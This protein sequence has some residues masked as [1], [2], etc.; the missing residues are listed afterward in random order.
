[1]SSVHDEDSERSPDDLG[2]PTFNAKPVV[3][4]P[5]ADSIGVNA[6]P[7]AS[8]LASICNS[9]HTISNVSAAPSDTSVIRL[10]R[11]EALARTVHLRCLPPFLKQKALADVFEDCGEYLRVRI[12]GNATTHQKWVYG[13]VEFATKDAAMKMMTYCGMELPNGPDKPPLRFKCSPSKQPILDCMAYDADV[14]KGTP[15]GFGRG[16]LAERTLNDVLLLVG[17]G[18]SNTN[19]TTAG[20]ASSSGKGCCGGGVG[21]RRMR[22]ANNAL[23]A[24]TVQSI[25]KVAANG[26]GCGCSGVN[27]CGCC[28]CWKGLPES[29][30]STTFGGGEI[31]SGGS[32]KGTTKAV[33]ATVPACG[34]AGCANGDGVS[35]RETYQGD[36][37]ATS[38][39]KLPQL[40][41]TFSTFKDL[42][43]P[44]M[45]PGGGAPRD[46]MQQ[47]ATAFQGLR[48]ST[49]THEHQLDGPSIV[50]RAEAMV[51]A[52]LHRAFHVSSDTC[53]QDILSELTQVLAFLD[54][55]AAVTGGA[56]QTA[57][58]DSAATL[59]QRVT[60]L[61]MLAN[62]VGALLCLLRRRVGDA[63]PH[64]EAVLVIFAQIPPSTLL[65]RTRQCGKVGAVQE[66]HHAEKS[67]H[68]QVLGVSHG[69]RGPGAVEGATAEL[70]A[71]AVYS[72][73]KRRS[74]PSPQLSVFVD[75]DVT[76]PLLE[77]LDEDNAYDGIHHIG[78]HDDPLE[79]NDIESRD[80][81]TALLKHRKRSTSSCIYTRD[82]FPDSADPTALCLRDELFSRYVLHA[83]VSVGL[84]MEEVHPGIARSVYTLANGRAMEV[85]G[86][87]SKVLADQ[88]ATAPTSNPHLC[89]ALFADA[90]TTDSEPDITFFP[91]QFF[92]G[93]SVVLQRLR[94]IRGTEEFWR[95]LPPNHIVT[96]FNT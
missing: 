1:M 86:E 95:Q 27:C 29:T 96:L 66:Q 32:A 40:T 50:Q 8:L 45:L 15:C 89:A 22:A 25:R 88:L 80:D 59:P 81:G 46:I 5:V 41:A 7:A 58:G 19:P 83:L 47:L 78:N 74:L 94:D 84:A 39:G 75:G 24:L 73:I 93:V 42:Q 67:K 90:Y 54:S 64:V 51:L 79:E 34:R 12:C 38:A 92:E 20:G 69:G 3:A 30:G 18:G 44:L 60:Q 14:V 65:L 52:A 2:S 23:T 57:S 16:Y 17:G 4:A 49:A 10:S 71:P 68:A 72:L 33:V 85:F 48:D 77:M 13:F 55:N 6:P 11:T 63:L 87:S 26:C 31:P 9:T 82:A 37:C 91:H 56:A 62:L 35:E 21:D 43:L 76:G 28:N 70:Y 61:R 36:C 53:I